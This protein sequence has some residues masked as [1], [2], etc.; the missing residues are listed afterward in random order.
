MNATNA[1]NATNRYNKYNKHR[2]AEVD[3]FECSVSL[4]DLLECVAV[5]RFVDALEVES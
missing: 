1:T 4:V 2:T 5:R 3:V